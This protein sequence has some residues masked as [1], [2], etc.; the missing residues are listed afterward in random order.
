[1]KLWVSS[2]KVTWCKNGTN[3]LYVHAKYDRDWWTHGD[4]KTMVFLFVCLFVCL[5]RWMSRK[6]VRTFNNV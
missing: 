3:V 6:E 1:M 2:E 4:R 5:S